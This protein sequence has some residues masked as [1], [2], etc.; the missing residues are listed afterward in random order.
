M[1]P[2][3]KYEVS[4]GVPGPC[5]T[6][7][8]LSRMCR[9]PLTPVRL[10][11]RSGGVTLMSYPLKVGCDKVVLVRDSTVELVVRWFGLRTRMVVVLDDTSSQT[12]RIFSRFPLGFGYALY[13][14]H[15]YLVDEDHLNLDEWLV[16]LVPVVGLLCYFYM[17]PHRPLSA[18]SALCTA[19][20]G[21][22]VSIC[23]LAVF[24]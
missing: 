21:T 19:V 20:V 9:Y 7:L 22:L 14:A 1:R 12:C 15:D 5:A 4:I 11:V 17:R 3:R 24:L 13:D 6:R 2:S 18:R 10:D 16:C 8:R 23:T